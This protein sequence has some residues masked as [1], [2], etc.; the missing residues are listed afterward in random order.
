M[1]PTDCPDFEGD[2]SGAR[3]KHTEPQR[4]EIGSCATPRSGRHDQSPRPRGTRA[5]DRERHRWISPKPQVGLTQ[6][7]A[8][9]HRSRPLDLEALGGGVPIA[10]KR[11]RRR[12]PSLHCGE[13]TCA[14]VRGCLCGP[15]FDR[16]ASMQCQILKPEDVCQVSWAMRW[17]MPQRLG[18][19]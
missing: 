13:R 9:W 18:C 6:T 19:G 15:R 1:R 12:R 11:L 16:R 4:C 17:A 14:L 8:G 7:S 5:R 2:G 10:H 3:L